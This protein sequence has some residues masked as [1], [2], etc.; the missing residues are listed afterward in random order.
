[1]SD[2]LFLICFKKTKVKDMKKMNS[3]YTLFLFMGALCAAS[4]VNASSTCSRLLARTRQPV[5]R[6]LVVRS[7]STKPVSNFTPA[8]NEMFL[9]DVETPIK[10]GSLLTPT[11]TQFKDLPQYKQDEIIKQR[12]LDW[13]RA[14]PK[15]NFELSEGRANL[16]NNWKNAA[17]EDEARFKRDKMIVNPEFWRQSR[18]YDTDTLQQYREW[19]ASSW[20][21]PYIENAWRDKQ[22]ALKE[23]TP[24]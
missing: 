6:A 22:K 19:D 11:E 10:N 4:A 16:F 17:L 14:Q 1:M 5:S 7:L 24:Q 13:L 8:P 12:K 15:Q 3:K 23:V 20:D 21:A 18:D 2:K 9:H